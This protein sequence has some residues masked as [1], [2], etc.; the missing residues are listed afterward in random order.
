MDFDF[1]VIPYDPGTFAA[2]VLADLPR[3]TAV[4]KIFDV[5]DQLMVLDRTHNLFERLERYF[6]PH[7]P[8]SRDL[9]LTAITGRI[10]FRRT[11]S[12]LETAYLLYRE[13]RRFFPGSYRDMRTF[14]LFTLLKINCRQRFPRIYASEQI[15]SGVDYFGPF[16]SRAQLERLK[17]SIERTF[18]L[19]PCLYNIRGNDPHPDCLYFQ[20][21][22]C[23]RPCNDD[24]DRIA[25]LDTVDQAIAFIRGNDS[26]IA[27]R[28]R[29]TVKRLSE[30]MRFEEAA[31]IHRHLERVQRARAE[32]RES[33]QPVWELNCLALMPAGSATRCRIAFVRSGFIIGFEEYDIESVAPQLTA[34]LERYY[35]GTLGLKDRERQYD[36]F[37]LISNFIV[38]PVQ[39]VTLIAVDR[40]D[41]IPSEVLQRLQQRK[42]KRKR[43]HADPDT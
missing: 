37:C 38:K 2:D 13:R 31:V 8:L 42:R 9:D 26:A 12:P 18:K 41:Q 17:V 20:T 1:T 36:E 15:K 27:D 4:L 7:S 35:A 23:S 43:K 40:L 16:E 25:Y 5:H 21:H 14:R 30:E 3:N 11:D 29:E 22:A 19:R 28:H 33:F 34:D 10:E 32:T 24:I 6:A 39:N